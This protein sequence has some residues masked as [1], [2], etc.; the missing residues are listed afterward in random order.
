MANAHRIATETLAAVPMTA[1]GRPLVA[2]TGASG[3][4]GSVLVG[5]FESAGYAVRRLVRSPHPGTGDRF[6]DL[7]SA[8]SARSPRGSRP[9]RPLRLRPTGDEADRDL[10]DERLRYRGALRPGPRQR[11]GADDRAVVDVGLSG[12]PPA[13]RPGQAGDRGGGTGAG[14]VRRPPGSG[15]RARNGEAWRAPCAGWPRSRWSPTSAR[16]HVSSPWP[17]TTSPPR[18]S[19]SPGPTRCPPFRWGS[20]IPTRC[21]SP[22]CSPPSPPAWGDRGPGSSPAPPMAVY[23]ALRAAELLPV[24]LP[25][26]ADSLLGLVRPAPDVP[27]LDVLERPRGGAA[28]VRPGAGSGPRPRGRGA[29]VRAALTFGP[30][31]AP[32]RPSRPPSAGRGRR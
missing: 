28:A 7:T 17:K 25:V 8:V 15:V 31:W 2:I 16:R 22:S 3:Y 29:L 13:L 27:H 23:G 9:A 14:R 5:A 4:L 26:R 11:G 1:S 30:P 12:D 19:P 18:W 20:P 24:T 10:A 6:F 21:R 32:S